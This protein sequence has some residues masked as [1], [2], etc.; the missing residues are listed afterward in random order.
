MGWNKC[1]T[2]GSSD[3]E[4]SMSMAEETNNV[5]SISMRAKAQVLPL[6]AVLY[7][8]IFSFQFK[9][10]LLTRKE[11]ETHITCRSLGLTLVT[12]VHTTYTYVR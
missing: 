4:A 5:V 1:V 9:I 7:Y 3:E 6:F 11:E 12:S 10:K 2:S 8:I